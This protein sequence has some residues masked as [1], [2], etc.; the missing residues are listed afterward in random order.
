MDKLPAVNVSGALVIAAAAEV[1]GV[2]ERAIRNFSSPRR[3]AVM[4]R[5]AC[6]WVLDQLSTESDAARERMLG[7]KA[8][9]WFRSAVGRATRYRE[10]DAEFQL[11]ADGILSAVFGLGRLGLSGNL[12]G[13]DTDAEAR[14]IA[15]DP[16]RAV[17]SAPVMVLAAIVEDHV[18]ALDVLDLVRAWLTAEQVGD[19]EPTLDA[20][21]TAVWDALGIDQ[22]ARDGAA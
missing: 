13:I 3:D 1:F 4:A 5:D 16:L 10:D 17:K 19:K 11:M 20:L 14:R 22:G 15:I 6:A 9:G 8:G 2:P 21:R 7:A 12:S 18:D